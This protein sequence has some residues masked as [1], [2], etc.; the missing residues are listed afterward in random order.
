M[1]KP[2]QER[3]WHELALFFKAPCALPVLETMHNCGVMGCLF[4]TSNNEV[5]ILNH[6]RNQESLLIE[7]E[8]T[9][10][11]FVDAFKEST[12]INNQFLLKLS[13][14]LQGLEQKTEFTSLPDEWNHRASNAEIKFM[15][16]SIK[17]AR[18]LAGIDS[19][20]ALNPSEMYE[21]T[22][23]IHNELLASVVLFT[24]GNPL[25]KVVQLSNN[26]L[27]FY[28]HQFLPAI[29]ERPLLNGEDLIHQLNLSPS[30]LF[31]KIL[32]HVQKEQVLG[33]IT[34]H[35]EALKL[36]RELIQSPLTES[37]E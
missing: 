9:F 32:N 8:K 20:H 13:V 18:H 5:Q 16:Q 14:L 21:L 11:D 29:N 1:L 7:P 12:F 2:A 24:S 35:A 22:Q 26:I 6:Y 37:K 27:K 19:G 23:T 15:V 4:P 30:P 33:N 36:A 31:G 28:Y 25:S 3:I 17:G 10:P 34:T